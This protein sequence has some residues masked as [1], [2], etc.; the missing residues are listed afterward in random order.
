MRLLTLPEVLI[1]AEAVT[2]IDAEILVKVSRIELLESAIAAS[3]AGF[4]NFEL[5]PEFIDKA[6]VLCSRIVRNHAL[7]DG[8]KRLGWQSLVVFCDI[9]G[10]E[11]M[12]EPDEAVEFIQSLAA[13]I[14]SELQLAEWIR[15]HIQKE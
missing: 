10:Y 5:H 14:I 8:N 11:L 7:P 12:A 2:G 9:N 4:G 3:Q 6:A 13:G 15:S 1:I